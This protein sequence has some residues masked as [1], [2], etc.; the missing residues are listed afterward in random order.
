L[1]GNASTNAGGIYLIKHGS[2]RSHILGIEAVLPNGNVLNLQSEIHKDNT[3]YDIKHLFIGGE[4]TL[5]MITKLNIHCSFIDAN[6]KI[7]VMKATNYA[8]VIKA[9]PIIK[10]QFGKQL[11]ALEY[12][13]GLAYQT[14]TKWVPGKFM[15][16]DSH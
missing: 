14:V 16:V 3:G 12:A 9:I 7:I 2:F 10:S 5:G 4:G 13:D 11:N 6:R 15:E 1:G 8:D